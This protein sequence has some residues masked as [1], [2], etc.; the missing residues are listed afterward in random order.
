MPFE[1]CTQVDVYARRVNRSAHP[2][3][4][5]RNVDFSA[6]TAALPVLALFPAWYVAISFFFLV[7][8]PLLDLSYPLFLVVAALGSVVMFLPLTQRVFVT[9]MLGVRRLRAEER[10]RIEPAL[11][12]VAASAGATRRRFVL[13]IEDS[14]ELNAFACG[15]HILVVSSFAL[16]RLD[17]DALTA[18]VAHEFAHHLG[19]HTVGL[20]LAQWFSLPVI[21]C[22]RLGSFLRRISGRMIHRVEGGSIVVVSIARSVAFLIDVVARLFESTLV[23]VQHLNDRVGHG[24]EFRADRR[25]VEM[26]FGRQLVTALTLVADIDGSA[27]SRNGDARESIYS[28]HPP[29]RTRI[30]RIEAM[31]RNRRR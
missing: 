19:A 11:R 7:T 6:L 22:A 8:T 14:V 25:V 31:L 29:A 16:D 4:E 10:R 5:R 20:A 12:I 18:V 28:S 27:H 1:Q 21:A 13:A 2:R 17:D 9:R 26:G 30:A 15:G 3:R 23:A 24:A